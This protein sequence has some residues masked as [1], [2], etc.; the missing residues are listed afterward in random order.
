MLDRNIHFFQLH[1]DHTLPIIAHKSTGVTRKR[2]FALASVFQ[3]VFDDDVAPSA[4]TFDA[5]KTIKWFMFISQAQGEAWLKLTPFFGSIYNK[6]RFDK[7]FQTCIPSVRST[8][9]GPCFPS[10]KNRATRTV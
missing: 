7:E 10:G 9:S 4:A 5:A 2:I 6:L 3:A 1:L 8:R